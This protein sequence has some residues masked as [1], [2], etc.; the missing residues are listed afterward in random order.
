MKAKKIRFLCKLG[1]H[2]WHSH[3]Y[4]KYMSTPCGPFDPATPQE[5]SVS[6][7]ICCKCGLEEDHEED[8]GYYYC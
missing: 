8:Y 6:R 1:V 3:G 2:C 4:R 7:R 5:Q